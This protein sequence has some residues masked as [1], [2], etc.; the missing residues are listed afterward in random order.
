M[1]SGSSSSKRSAKP[2]NKKST[3][4]F[5]VKEEEKQAT[6]N[7]ITQRTG[8]GEDALSSIARVNPSSCY[9]YIMATCSR[10]FST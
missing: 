5:K 8:I 6:Y 10:T 9:V 3:A 7:L 1:G 4:I 2:R